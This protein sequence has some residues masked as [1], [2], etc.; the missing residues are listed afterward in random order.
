MESTSLQEDYE[1][2]GYIPSLDNR[3][4][5][6][7]DPI[8]QER[9]K[10]VTNIGEKLTSF[11]FYR[12]LTLKGSLSKGK[13]LTLKNASQTDINMGV[14]LDF[15]GISKLT[16]LQLGLLCLRHRIA[17]Q[18][19]GSPVSV[20]DGK[21]NIFPSQNLSPEE[22][23]RIRLVRQMANKVVQRQGEIFFKGQAAKPSA[24]WPEIAIYSQEG[25]F[26]IYSTLKQHEEA[27]PDKSEEERIAVTRALAL[28][29]G[30]VTAGDL[31]EYLKAF[32]HKLRSL[33]PEIAEQKWQTTR[34]AIIQN[35]RPG[36]VPPAIEFQFP[37]TVEEAT[38]MYVKES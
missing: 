18:M 17:Y 5:V 21:Y 12:G 30:M 3:F 7:P 20:N 29:F 14:I 11:P 33:S 2:R 37:K 38:R 15:D 31:N 19:D 6:S 1:F 4:K 35:E 27:S 13:V 24:I 23:G 28:P 10:F 25:P 36:K 8:S 22:L 26:S 32:F 34:K 9:Y 16:E